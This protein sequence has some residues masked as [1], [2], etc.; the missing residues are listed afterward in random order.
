MKKKKTEECKS[1]IINVTLLD[2]L[3]VKD[4]KKEYRR[5]TLYQQKVITYGCRANKTVSVH[6]VDTTH[7]DN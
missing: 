5:I 6:P 7:W 2:N 4:E 1:N 3:I